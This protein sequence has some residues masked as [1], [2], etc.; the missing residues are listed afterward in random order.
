MW[1]QPKLHAIHALCKDKSLKIT[2]H[3]PCLIFLS[4]KMGVIEWIPGFCWA[5]SHFGWY[6]KFGGRG[7]LCWNSAQFRDEKKH[8]GN[9]PFLGGMGWIL[10]GEPWILM[11]RCKWCKVN[12]FQFWVGFPYCWTLHLVVDPCAH[13]ATNQGDPHDTSTNQTIGRIPCA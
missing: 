12:S 9:L 1:H 6:R 3:L 8:G 11:R 13:Q 10:C 7:G 2:R 5:G 4:S